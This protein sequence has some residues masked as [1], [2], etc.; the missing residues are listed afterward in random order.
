MGLE[1]ASGRSEDV[2]TTTLRVLTWNVWGR[3]GPWQRR[4]PALVRTLKNSDPDVVT[5]QESWC[6]RSGRDQAASLAEV[7]GYHSVYGGGNF[8]EKDWGTGVAVLSRSPITR[9]EDR[10]FRSCERGTWGGCATFAAVDGPREQLAIFS[11]ILDWPPHASVVRQDSV[12]Q[13]V[14]FVREVAAIPFPSVIGG[15]FNAPPDSDEIRMLT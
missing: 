3:F 1:G 9:H 12:R 11:V 13:L 5:L 7:L 15:D 10:E 8:L 4:E 6:D 14:S 2:I